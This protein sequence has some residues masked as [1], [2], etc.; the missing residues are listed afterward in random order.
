VRQS[1]SE[2]ARLAEPIWFT[3]EGE[4]E[5][6]LGGEEMPLPPICPPELKR[7][8]TQDRLVIDMIS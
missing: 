8:T 6:K 5:E 3:D 1:S 4:E 2:R 7:Q